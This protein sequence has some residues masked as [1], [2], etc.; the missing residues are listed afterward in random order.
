[1]GCDSP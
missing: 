1:M